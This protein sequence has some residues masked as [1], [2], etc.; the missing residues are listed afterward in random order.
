MDA[1]LVV[2]G[3][4]L[5][6]VGGTALSATGVTEGRLL[7]GAAGVVGACTAAGSAWRRLAGRGTP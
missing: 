1:R 4:A 6:V 5:L 3:I 7:V 2:A